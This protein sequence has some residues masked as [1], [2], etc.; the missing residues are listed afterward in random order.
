MA[1]MQFWNSRRARNRLPR[2][3]GKV[4]LKLDKPSLSNVVGFKVGML[5]LSL[6]QNTSNAL[7]VEAFKGATILEIPE[8]EVYGIRLYKKDQKTGYVVSSDTIYD[9]KIA[10][11]LNMKKI[12]LDTQ[13]LDEFKKKLNDYE[14]VSALLVSYPKTISAEQNH[15]ERYESKIIG[16]SIESNFDFVASL[17]GKKLQPEDVFKVGEHIDLSSVSKGKGW[18]G[19]IKRKGVRRQFHK[20]TEKIRHVGALGAFT[21]GKILYTTPRAGQMGY[22]YRT[23]KNK[24]LLKISDISKDDINPKSG[25]KNYG[26]IKGNYLIVSGSVPGTSKRVVRVRKSLSSNKVEKEVNINYISTKS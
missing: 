1:G 18:Q 14:R 5:S 15:I 23:E 24:V 19:P 17:I 6:I 11:K 25:F 12:K 3:R 2:L 4:N 10:E 9:K 8:T 21:P 22:N 7:N 16:D 20:A 26:L 13:K